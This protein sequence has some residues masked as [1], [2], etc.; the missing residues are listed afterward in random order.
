MASHNSPDPLGPPRTE[1]LVAVLSGLWDLAR[2][3]IQ[4]QGLWSGSASTLDP[5]DLNS[6]SFNN[7]APT[8]VDST[9][10]FPSPTQT[11]TPL[12]AEPPEYTNTSFTIDNLLRHAANLPLTTPT[13][14]GFIYILTA[15]HNNTPLVKIGYTSKA[16]DTRLT[17][18]QRSCPSLQIEAAALPSPLFTSTTT[19]SPPPSHNDNNNQPSNRLNNNNNNHALPSHHAHHVE[20]LAHAELRPARYA[21][22]CPDCSRRHREFFAVDSETAY[23][24]VARWVRFCRGGVVPWESISPPIAGVGPVGSGAVLTAPWRA[25]LDGYAGLFLEEAAVAVGREGSIEK[26][27]AL[28]D[29]FVDAGVGAWVWHDA[30]RGWGVLSRSWLWAVVVALA[31]GGAVWCRS[32]GFA[33]LAWAMLGLLVVLLALTVLAL[34]TGPTYGRPAL[35]E[36]LLWLTTVV[37]LMGLVGVCLYLGLEWWAWVLTWML[38]D[39][40]M[41]MVLVLMEF[42][43]VAAEYLGLEPLPSG[44]LAGLLMIVVMS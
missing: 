40:F 3:G 28:W 43:C 18:M 26:G 32:V 10:V 25:R 39:V 17:A 44:V 24:I 8:A 13:T 4:R 30:R 14:Q 36:G 38:V 16:V 6:T 1:Y 31:M 15:T 41:C 29:G 27:M 22:R 5:D 20:K 12:T 2:H 23:R 42:R 35:C 7:E 37:L 19:S 34:P 9:P 21:F 33:A 11:N